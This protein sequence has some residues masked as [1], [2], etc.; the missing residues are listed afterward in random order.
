MPAILAGMTIPLSGAGGLFTRIGHLAGGAQDILAIRGGAATARV[1]AGGNMAARVI[2]TIEPDFAAGTPIPQVI[3]GIIA[4]LGT[5]QNALGV[6]PLYLQQQS[7]QQLLKAMYSIDQQGV[8]NTAP[9]AQLLGSVTLQQAL[10]TLIA[11]MNSGAQSVNASTVAAGAQTAVGTPTGNPVIITSLK[12]GQGQT[13]QLVFPETVT[14]RCTLDSQ[15]GGATAFNEPML[16]AGQ[17]TVSDVLSQLYPGGSGCAVALSAV[18]AA[19]NNSQG[20]LLV[21]SDFRTYSTANYP[22]NW[23]TLVGVAGTDIFNGTSGGAYF[24]GGGAV[25]FTGTGGALLDAIYQPFNTASTTGAGTGG[26]PATL[27]PDTVYHWNLYYK[28]S[29]TPAAGVLEVALTDGTNTVV[30]DDAATANSKTQSL[31]AATGTYAN[32]N[33][34]FRTP[35][36]LPTTG[37]RLRVRLSTAIDSGKSAFVAGLSFAPA[38]SLYTGGPWVSAHSGN[39]RQIA[40]LSPDTWTVAYTNT[41][42][43]LQDWC[44][45]FWGM[46]LLGLQLPFSGSPTLADSLVA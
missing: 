26:T 6:F 43:V 45:R 34:T 23:V 14:F 9:L 11:Q 30:N 16:A 2:N 3:D 13:W 28:V 25:Q 17:T 44:D 5:F 4:A 15:T 21:N 22:D 8:S 36:V 37:L 35:A 32:L 31:T 7:A 38:V 20:N 12:N 18:N 19:G 29:A 1:L 24:T 41:R 46:R 33:G 10:T 27:A 40:G 39:V 42:G